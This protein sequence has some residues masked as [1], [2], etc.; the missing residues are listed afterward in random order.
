MVPHERSLVN[1]LTGKPFV[2]L[3]VDCDADRS[4]GKAA[5]DAH[6]INWRSW[7]FELDDLRSVLAEWKV[8]GLPTIFVIDARGAIRFRHVGRPGDDELDRQVD[9]LVAEIS[10]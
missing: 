4:R 10:K 7:H 9:Q 8:E 1:R 2:L 3:G 5:V 6:G